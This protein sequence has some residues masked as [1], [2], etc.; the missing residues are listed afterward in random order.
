[1]PFRLSTRGR[2]GIRAI[3][4]LARHFGDKPISTKIIAREEHIPIRYLEQIMVRLRREG[5]VKSSRGPGGGY[6]LTRPPDR[7]RLG[8]V[9]R[10][11]EGT[12]CLVSCTDKKGNRPCSSEAT[13]IPKYFWSKLGSAIQRTLD[14]TSVLE[15]VEKNW[16]EDSVRTPK[17]GE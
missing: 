10:I 6:T 16:K 1:M 2:Y 13:C 7:I 11:L 14:E 9:L 12:V 3:A 8:D 15:L 4:K 17:A 5:I